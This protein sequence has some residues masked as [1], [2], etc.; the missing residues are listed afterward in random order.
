MPVDYKKYPKNWKSEIRPRILKRAN[1]CCEFCGL[2]N[3]IT[4]YRDKEGKFY[5]SMEIMNTLDNTGYDYFEHELAHI[6]EDKGPIKIVL[7]IAHLDHD[8]KNNSDDN[9]KALCP[10][11]HLNH[12]KYLHLK[13]R[14]Q[15]KYKNQMNIFDDMS[16]Y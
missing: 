6:P 2:E 1:N 12:D 5:E 15:K 9:L 16:D 4:G 8:I 7:T 10:K 13:S 11:C 3:Y 14:Q